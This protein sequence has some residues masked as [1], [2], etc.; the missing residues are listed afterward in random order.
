M[1]KMTFTT[2]GEKNPKPAPI[3]LKPLPRLG[4]FMSLTSLKKDSKG[5][6]SCGH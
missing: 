5:C 4:D 3:V 1:F 2:G 6:K